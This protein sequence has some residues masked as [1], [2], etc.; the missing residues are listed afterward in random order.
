[1]QKKAQFRYGLP[2]AT[3]LAYFDYI[4]SNDESLR[5]VSRL[6]G[7]SGIWGKFA[8]IRADLS[9]T[10]GEGRDLGFLLPVLLIDGGWMDAFIGGSGFCEEFRRSESNGFLKVVNPFTKGSFSTG[11]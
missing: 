11:R 1:M 3:V 2:W 10:P 6:L 8:D 5:L 9:S 7:D 4:Q